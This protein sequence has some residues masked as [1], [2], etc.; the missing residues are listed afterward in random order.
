MIILCLSTACQ[1]VSYVWQFVRDSSARTT[2]LIA[3]ERLA[4]LSR[5]GN[6]IGLTAEPAPYSMPPVDLF[7]RKL[8]LDRHAKF[9]G[10]EPDV[11]FSTTDYVAQDREQSGWLLEYWIRPRLASTPISWAAKPYKVWHRPS[12][13]E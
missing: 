8:V 1:G 9:E 10:F 11:L 5:N 2:R 3:A 4:R 7:T 6:T 13:T 12:Q